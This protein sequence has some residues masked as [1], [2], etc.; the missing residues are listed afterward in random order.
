MAGKPVVGWVSVS[1]R[2]HL[3][4]FTTIPRFWTSDDLLTV[5]SQS[6]AVRFHGGGRIGR[7][8]ERAAIIPV[9]AERFE[10]KP[11]ETTMSIRYT[12]AALLLAAT[13]LASPVLANATHDLST[14]TAVWSVTTPANVTTTAQNAAYVAWTTMLSPAQ[15]VSPPGSP[16][17]SGV[18]VYQTTFKAH[19]NCTN[20]SLSGR[21]LGDNSVNL[22]FDGTLIASSQG[23]PNYGFL[24]GSVTPFSVA[25]FGPGAHTL[26]AEVTNESGPTG[27]V[28]DAEKKCR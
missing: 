8:I 3:L 13:A 10:F 20:G 28:V 17:A 15:W 23:T 16:T 21:F 12:S 7:L 26:K 24:P 19:K 25:S 1:P 27:V 14:G 6:G 11:K 18:Y 9:G 5:T 4:L 22:Y 2:R